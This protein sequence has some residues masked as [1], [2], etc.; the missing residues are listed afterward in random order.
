MYHAINP[1]L[2]TMAN[3]TDAK[4]KLLFYHIMGNVVGFVQDSSVQNASGTTANSGLDN[5]NPFA[6]KPTTTTT[7]AAAPAA[8]APQVCLSIRIG[9]EGQ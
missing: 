2:Y 7:P 3:D 1:I 5:Y 6:Q 9:Q 4:S 8:A